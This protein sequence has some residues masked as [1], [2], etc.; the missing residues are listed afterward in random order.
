M[1]WEWTVLHSH[2]TRTPLPIDIIPN[3]P[4]ISQTQ[5]L[6]RRARCHKYSF[7]LRLL[8]I[9]KWDIKYTRVPS[10]GNGPY[11][12]A[13]PLED[14]YPLTSCRNY[15][16]LV[17]ICY[18]ITA[19]TSM[20]TFWGR[21]EM[22]FRCSHTLYMFTGAKHVKY[23]ISTE[24]SFPS[25]M[26]ILKIRKNLKILKWFHTSWKF[27]IKILKLTTYPFKQGVSRPR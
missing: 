15:P 9:L 12:I 13:T 23:Y 11:C 7:V 3:L 2:T 1:E 14:I 26:I 25:L 4:Q 19:P 10:N 8:M 18:Y 21:P 6:Y 22:A 17:Q 16:K 5:L 20:C 27:T 24:N